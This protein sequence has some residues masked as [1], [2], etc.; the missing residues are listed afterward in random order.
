MLLITTRIG[1]HV[2]DY[3]ETDRRVDWGR[4]VLPKSGQSVDHRVFLLTVV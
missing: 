3:Y 1:S 2:V 4:L